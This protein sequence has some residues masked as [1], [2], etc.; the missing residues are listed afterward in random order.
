[1]YNGVDSR[2]V[3]GGPNGDEPIYKFNM[4]QN[5]DPCLALFVENEY[6]ALAIEAYYSAQ[7]DISQI[8]KRLKFA[9]K[10]Y[11]QGG[12]NLT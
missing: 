12:H 7:F 11:T 6:K 5:I 3:Q 9:L 1:M 8:Q 4:M 2:K 10:Q